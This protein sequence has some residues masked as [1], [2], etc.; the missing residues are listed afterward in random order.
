MVLQ[1][2]LGQSQYSTKT[3]AETDTPGHARHPIE[4]MCCFRVSGFGFRV[5]GAG[6]RAQGAGCRVCRVQGAGC[7]VQSVGV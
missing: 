3:P 6:C 1:I 7:R 5:Q 4:V 2:D